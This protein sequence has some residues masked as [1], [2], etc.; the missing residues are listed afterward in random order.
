MNYEESLAWLSGLQGRGWRLGLDRMRAFVRASG[1]N[2]VLGGPGSPIQYLHVAG[3]NGKGST[4]AYLQSM[5]VAQG[6]R[7]GGYFS[8]YVVDPRERI[9]IG[10]ELI[11][12]KEFAA[13][14]TEL[15]EVAERFDQTE[16]GGVTEFE[17]KTAMGFLAWK[18]AGVEVVAL[19]VGLGGRLDATNVVMPAAC[20][21]VS[22]SLDHTS[23]L[24]H[25]EAEIAREKAGI[26]KP[27]VPC[28]I[29]PLGE[30][31]RSTIR[32]IAEE[33]DAPLLIAGEAHDRS[34]EGGAD[35]LTISVGDA[36]G[37]PGI[38]GRHQL[39]NARVAL[40]TLEAGGYL[41]D[42]QRAARGLA[43]TRLPG[44]MH[45]VKLFGRPVLVDG[46]HNPDSARAL[47]EHLS[48]SP[49]VAIIGM[50][51]G[52]DPREFFSATALGYIRAKQWGSI[53]HV[54]AVPVDNPRSLAPEAVAEA[55]R[56]QGLRAEACVSLEAALRRVNELP[57]RPKERVVITG[58]LYLAGEAIRLAES[59]S[60]TP[61]V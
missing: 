16:E 40:A 56:S 11:A 31:A 19:E 27:G 2:D 57:T 54:L 23:I 55:A 9:Q 41:R 30:E 45:E 51:D 8:P 38:P 26:V 34:A 47:V 50:L 4:T 46:A 60:E 53:D 61:N 33:R 6:Y 1:L 7:T 3:T 39:A 35:R 32:A 14:A 24:G 36:W 5:L 21:I 25:T 10:G 28:V 17:V 12:K 42:P 20:A 13:V 43:E 22:I 59:A 29:G 15:R 58:S 52:H 18:R 48:T 37:L 44:R 49:I